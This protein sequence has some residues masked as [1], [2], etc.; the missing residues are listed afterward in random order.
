MP[1]TQDKQALGAKLHINNNLENLLSKKEDNSISGISNPNNSITITNIKSISSNSSNNTLAKGASADSFSI[2][3]NNFNISSSAKNTIK[4]DN[5]M[6]LN[7]INLNSNARNN[8]ASDSFNKVNYME[9][10]ETRKK[11]VELVKKEFNDL[12][13]FLNIKSSEDKNAS[14]NQLFKIDL[15]AGKNKKPSAQRPGNDDEYDVIEIERD[16][17][18]NLNKMKNMF[19]DFNLKQNNDEDD[20]LDL[21]DFA[22]K[23]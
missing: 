13:D 19:D 8:L 2:N 10:V 23:R 14:S 7:L 6:N 17:N 12:A 1:E 11:N 22:S 3:S 15:F 4:S 5:N 21:M 9:D 20:L 16:N 18:E